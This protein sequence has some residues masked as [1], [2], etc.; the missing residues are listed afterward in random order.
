MDRLPTRTRSAAKRAVSRP[1]VPCRQLIRFHGYPASNVSDAT[2]FASGI[3]SGKRRPL[4]C[5]QL[6]HPLA[7]YLHMQV[8]SAGGLH[9]RHPALLNQFHG[10][11]LEL[12]AELPSVNVSSS[13]MIHLFSVSHE[14]G[15]TSPVP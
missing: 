10:L 7:Q 13:S 1:F 8:E 12:Q 2:D 3:W 9:R 11:E 4:I 14:T 15:I 6:D 5:R